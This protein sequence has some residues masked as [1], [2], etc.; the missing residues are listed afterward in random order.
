MSLF[1]KHK[2]FRIFSSKSSKN[3]TSATTF[4][5]VVDPYAAIKVAFGTNVDPNN[6]LNYANQGKPA[7]IN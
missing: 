2:C 7:Y 3:E 6:L 1:F 5:V 4:P